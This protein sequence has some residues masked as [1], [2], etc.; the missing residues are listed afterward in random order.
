M[1]GQKHPDTEALAS[2]R[3]GLIGGL[4]GRRLASHVAGCARCASVSD[5]LGAVSSVLASV[6]A[7]ALPDDFARQIS[8]A[9]AA[10]AAARESAH[11]AATASPAARS[12]D[13]DSAQRV[14]PAPRPRQPA[15]PHRRQHGFRFR[16]AMAVVPVIAVVLAGFGYLLSHSSP[17][18]SSSSALS[19]AAPSAAA[20]ASGP[21]PAGRAAA[22][23]AAR[24][25]HRPA[26]FVTESGTR[27]QAASLR[28]QVLGELASNSAD[29]TAPVP[30]AAAPAPASSP[31]SQFAAGNGAATSGGSAPSANLIGCALALTG[32][33]TPSLVDQAFYQG[34]PVY[35]I[36][37]PNHAWVV[38]RGCTASHPAVIASVS[39]TAAP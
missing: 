8:A 3:A 20:S 9:L 38:G 13:R 18:S 22:G 1:S 37:V 11:G 2:L 4:R 34:K 30:S 31:S 29:T 36:A 17:S 25:N 16:P 35:V 15:G 19:E 6:P 23:A 12:A 33:V 5:Q 39:L 24:P 14:A 28:A 21:E 10:E 7:P 27:Y 26:F 32:K